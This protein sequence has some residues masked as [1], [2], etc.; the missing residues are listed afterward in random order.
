M[1][2]YMCDGLVINSWDFE[3]EFLGHIFYNCLKF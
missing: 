3:F 1:G 2:F